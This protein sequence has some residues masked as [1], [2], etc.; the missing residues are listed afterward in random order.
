MTQVDRLS[1]TMPPHVGG[2][3]RD[4]ATRAGVS[5]SSWITAAASQRLRNELLG[6]ALHAW[7]AEAG[8]LS[9][10]ELAGAAQALSS[11][12][13]DLSSAAQA[14]ASAAHSAAP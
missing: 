1:V 12:A 2:A 5:V 14:P 11:A 13:Q 6:A 4:A 8:P 7:E 3:V 9:P 10:Q